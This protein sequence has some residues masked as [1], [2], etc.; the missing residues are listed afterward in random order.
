MIGAGEKG[1]PVHLYGQEKIMA[2]K[3]MSTEAFNIIASDQIS[4]HRTVPGNIYIFFW[5]LDFTNNPHICVSM[6]SPRSFYKY[7][8]KKSIKKSIFSIFFFLYI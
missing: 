1:A 4:M 3:L 5:Y 2:E 7:K 8:T 6:A